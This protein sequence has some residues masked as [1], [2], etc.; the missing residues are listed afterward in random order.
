MSTSASRITS[1][2]T[3]TTSIPAA[4]QMSEHE[5]MSGMNMGDMTMAGL[6]HETLNT[7]DMY[8]YGFAIL[9]DLFIMGVYPI[10]F[11]HWL[12]YPERRIAFSIFVNMVAWVVTA[13]W[14]LAYSINSLLS[15][16]KEGKF[17]CFYWICR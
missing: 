12:R 7:I 11:Y 5:D 8:Q 16:G 15:Y 13:V 4:T 14:N 9:V 3:G 10:H 1:N 2:F 17:L 6:T